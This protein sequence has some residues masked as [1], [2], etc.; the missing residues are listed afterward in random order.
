MKLVPDEF[1]SKGFT[2]TKIKREGDKAIYKQS[3]NGGQNYRYEVVVIGRHNGYKL[4]ES[5]IEPSE[6]YPGS[7]LWG[8]KGWTCSTL[9]DAERRYKSLSDTNINTDNEE[10]PESAET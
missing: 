8:I 3:H 5:Y 10:V 6:V 7:S 4:G 1:V 9:E 2:Y